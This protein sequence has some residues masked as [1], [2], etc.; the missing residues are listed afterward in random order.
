MRIFARAVA[1]A[2][3]FLVAA[4]AANAATV[5]RKYEYFTLNGRT[6]ADLDRELYR[7]GPLLQTNG[8]A[9]S[10]HDEDAVRKQNKVRFERQEL[11]CRRCQHNCSR[12]CLPATLEAAAYGKS[13]PCHRLGH[14]VSG[15][16]AAR[17]KPYLDSP[18]R[19]RRY[20]TPDKGPALA[21]GL[22]RL[23]GRHRRV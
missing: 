15:H 19:S 2:T 8:T 4:P 5:L 23:E 18:H 17:G 11:P 3:L 20:G 9:S 14:A 6:A 13:R 12:A 21:Q 1:F 22:C 7:R 16:Q 10:G